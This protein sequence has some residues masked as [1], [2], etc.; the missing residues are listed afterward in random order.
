MQGLVGKAAT[1]GGLQNTRDISADMELLDCERE[2][3]HMVLSFFAVLVQKYKTRAIFRLTWNCL[4]ANV[5]LYIW[6]SVYLLYWYKS[7]NTEAAG[8]AE[9]YLQHALGVCLHRRCLMPYALCLMPYPYPLCLLQ[10]RS[11]NMLCVC[12]Y[13]EDGD[14]MGVVQVRC[15]VYYS[16]H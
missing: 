14:F 6:Y 12:V 13:T 2:S 11:R 10:K 1:T 4:T 15:S 5:N 8:A 16:F 7:T 3:I 9:A